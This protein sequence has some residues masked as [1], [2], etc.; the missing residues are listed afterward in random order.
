[1]L[2]S[3]MSFSCDMQFRSLFEQ[4]LVVFHMIKELFFRLKG[5]AAVE[6]ACEY[7]LEIG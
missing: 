2:M 7:T 3:N 6:V 1:M 4:K 5:L